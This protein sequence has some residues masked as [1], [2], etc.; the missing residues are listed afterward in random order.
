MGY[1]PKHISHF[2]LASFLSNVFFVIYLKTTNYSGGEIGM[3]PFVTIL[4][5]IITFIISIT[6][7]LLLKLLNIYL[8][9]YM[10]LIM[11]CL[12]STLTLFI[13][14][15]V[16]PFEGYLSDVDLCAIISVFLACFIIGLTS[17]VKKKT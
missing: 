11:F 10:A 9:T 4:N 2:F 1:L 16:D 7:L 17:L 3:A 6:F 8:S 12:I 13:Y 14:F 15:K 5:T